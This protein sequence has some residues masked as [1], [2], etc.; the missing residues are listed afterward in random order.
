MNNSCGTCDLCC[1]VLPITDLNKPSG[2]H[3]DKLKCGKCSIY[4]SR[5]SVCRVWDC[6]WKLFDL[7]QHWK[8]EICGM[9]INLGKFPNETLGIWVTK[10]AER[11]EV[12]R[13]APYRDELRTIAIQNL[14]NYGQ[15]TFI[16]PWKFERGK[17]GFWVVGPSTGDTVR[18]EKDDMGAFIN[19]RTLVVRSEYADELQPLVKDP[20]KMTELGWRM[21]GDRLIKSS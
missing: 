9:V 20:G 11:D 17:P 14:A 18:A 15:L 10:K 12:W 3:C 4:K 13:R 7:P 8:P 16:Y 1:Y 21:R 2:R 6:G 5:P 19:G